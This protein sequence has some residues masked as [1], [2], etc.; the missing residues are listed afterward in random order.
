MKGAILFDNVENI[1]I[2]NTQFEGNT[3][4]NGASLA[5]INGGGNI[6]IDNVQFSNDQVTDYYDTIIDIYSDGSCT[7]PFWYTT[8]GCTAG[9]SSCNVSILIVKGI[10]GIFDFNY[11]FKSTVCGTSSLY[12][13]CY[14][15]T[16]C[17][18][19]E[20]QTN[21]PSPTISP[22]S[23]PSTIQS[24]I[25][26]ATVSTSENTNSSKTWIYIT[27]TIIVTVIIVGIIAGGI[28][29]VWKKRRANNFDMIDDFE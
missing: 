6:K 10:I 24:T 19:E 2:T 15:D 14:C 27:I 18:D 9:C 17:I 5:C 4:L 20:S 16:E 29:Y 22:S 25:Q 1:Q 21:S 8:E 23:S 11:L 12:C 7:S 28:F 13:N 26:T 3:A